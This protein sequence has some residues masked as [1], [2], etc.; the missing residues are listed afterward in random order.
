LLKKGVTLNPNI[1]EVN[2]LIGT[3]YLYH[4]LYEPGI[5]YLTKAVDL[6][7]YYFWAPYKLAMCYMSTEQSEKAAYHFEQY[8]ELAPV[9]FIFPQRPIALYIKMKNQDKVREL[10]AETEKINPDYW[11]INYGR[12]LLHATKGEKEKALKLHKNSEI[13]AL[14]GMKDEAFDHLEKEIRGTAFEPYIFYYELMNNPYYSKLRSDPRY[15]KFLEREK[16]L[17]EEAL[18]K[19]GKMPLKRE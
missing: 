19:Y 16:A 1:G 6:D 14:L 15:K 18:E 4:G 5:H 2:F 13:Y 3:C 11:G 9:I 17:Y 7:P 8:F 10:L 12:A